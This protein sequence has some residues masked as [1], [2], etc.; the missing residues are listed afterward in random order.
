MENKS[1]LGD[2]N[3]IF[4][5]DFRQIPPV[6]KYS[7]KTDILRKREGGDRH[8]YARVLRMLFGT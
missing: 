7:S 3:I 4:A 8:I 6:F 1:P 2:K 5:E